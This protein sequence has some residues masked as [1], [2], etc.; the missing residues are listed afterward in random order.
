MPAARRAFDPQHVELADQ[1]ADRSIW[2]HLRLCILAM[3]IGPHVPR[4]IPRSDET[5]WRGDGGIAENLGVDCWINSTQVAPH[6]HRPAAIAAAIAA[7]T[8]P[9][10]VH[11]DR[12]SVAEKAQ[13]G[14]DSKRDESLLSTHGNFLPVTR[15]DTDRI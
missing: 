3:T 2:W 9:V 15:R 12:R 13:G 5:I 1:T 11:R 8:T 6:H 14:G 10:I 4:A 7:I